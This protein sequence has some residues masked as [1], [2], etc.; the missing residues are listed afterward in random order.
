MD[1]GSPVRDSEVFLVEGS[2]KG[3][4]FRVN[5]MTYNKTVRDEE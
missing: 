3:P 5:K 2:D 4:F 1:F